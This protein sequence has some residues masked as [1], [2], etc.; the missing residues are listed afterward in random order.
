MCFDHTDIYNKLHIYKTGLYNLIQ[1]GHSFHL[2]STLIFLRVGWP[3]KTK[4]SKIYFFTPLFL[5]MLLRGTQK[6]LLVIS[7]Y[8]MY[9]SILYFDRLSRLERPPLPVNV[10]P[11]PPNSVPISIPAVGHWYWLWICNK[12]KGDR[13]LF[14]ASGY[15]T[16]CASG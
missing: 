9:E 11:N 3:L 15:L 8:Q 16:K 10:D 1:H 6:I 4:I 14:L 13:K 2:S 12:W 7:F 5:M